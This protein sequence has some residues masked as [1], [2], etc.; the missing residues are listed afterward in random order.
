MQF[1]STQNHLCS[2]STCCFQSR[3]KWGLM[4]QC[5]QSP[6][7]HTSQNGKE[8]WGEI[9]LLHQPGRQRSLDHALYHHVTAASLAQDPADP[10]LAQHRPFT[11]LKHPI[12]GVTTGYRQ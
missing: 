10:V 4:Q 2:A 5:N 8:G 1:S 9:Y 6:A 3:L 11:A 12:S 7:T